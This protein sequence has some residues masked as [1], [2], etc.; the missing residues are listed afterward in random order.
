MFISEFTLVMPGNAL[1]HVGRVRE[2]RNILEM[3][4]YVYNGNNCSPFISPS[5]DNGFG[6]ASF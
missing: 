4:N 3:A 6:G 5:D 1:H 2:T